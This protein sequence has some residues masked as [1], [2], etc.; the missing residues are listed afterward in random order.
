MLQLPDFNALS[1]EQDEVLDLPLDTSVIVTGPPG[2]GKTIIA[3][4]RAHMMHKAGRATLLLMYGRLLSTYTGAAVAAAGLDG[5]VSTYHSW[6]PKFFQESY[7]KPP[8][9][10][11]QYTFDWTAC[12]EVFMASPVP[13][14]Q[15]RHI[16]VDEGQDMPKDFYLALA[17]VSSSMTILADENQ[18]ITPDQS[19]LDEIRAATGVR[20]MRTLTT[21]YRNTRPIAEFAARFYTGLPSGIPDLPPASKGGER[22]S[23]TA[24]RN[25]H[26]A[27]QQILTYE[28]TFA[29]QSIGVLL[30]YAWQVKSFHN[31]LSGKTKN[32][33]HGY[34]SG[35]NGKALSLDFAKPGI[36]LVT[37]ASAKGLEFDAVF[38]PELQ[39]FKGDPSDAGFRMQM[40]VLSSRAKQ[41]LFLQYSGEG[42]PA[43][44]DS[45]PLD[46][47][48]DRR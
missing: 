47:V 23:L 12:R 15:R 17:L 27:V 29:N 37:W 4:W 35:R 24:H 38:L 34:L 22:P 11:D 7:G 16:I 40:Y 30:P 48:E 45:L 46:L 25:M 26:D 3:I 13:K 41:R 28:R 33:V 20:E 10:L 2:T 1:I 9:K 14:P 18:R 39:S 8:P 36:K 43:L 44:V 19:T 21:N 32:P 6:F 42:V 5:V 31:R